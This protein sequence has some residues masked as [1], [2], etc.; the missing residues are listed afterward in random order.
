MYFTHGPPVFSILGAATSAKQPGYGG[1]GVRYALQACRGCP[2]PRGHVHLG[3]E[4]RHHVHSQQEAHDA[5][6]GSEQAPR[7]GRCV[8]RRDK[9]PAWLDERTEG[10]PDLEL[11]AGALLHVLGDAAQV[12]HPSL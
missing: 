12:E 5:M 7:H 11:A 3:V 6:E 1:G 2:Q 9:T 4:L 8:V 10:A